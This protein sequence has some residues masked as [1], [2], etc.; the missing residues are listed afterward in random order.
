MPVSSKSVERLSGRP[1]ASLQ[2]IIP[3]HAAIISCKEGAVTPRRR[4]LQPLKEW[5]AHPDCQARDLIH[6]AEAKHLPSLPQEL[7]QIAR[8]PVTITALQSVVPAHA[9]VL[10]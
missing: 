8:H 7:R 5:I 1:G 6:A 9:G 4:H 2:A 10:V 3:V